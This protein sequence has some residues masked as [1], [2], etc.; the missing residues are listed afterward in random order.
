M[1]PSP[2][3]TVTLASHLGQNDGL[4]KGYVGSFPET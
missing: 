4:G 2:K 3:L 1:H